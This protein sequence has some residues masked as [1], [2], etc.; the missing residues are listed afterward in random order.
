[1]RLISVNCEIVM[2]VKM[3]FIIFIDFFCWM[4][5]IIIGVLFLIG[6]LFDLKKFV[7]VWIVVFVLFVNFFINFF[8]YIFFIMIIR[9]KLKF[10]RGILRKF[11]INNLFCFV[12]K[13][14]LYIRLFVICFFL[15]MI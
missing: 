4:L 5:V 12:G 3:M 14:K 11:I 15:E 2:V 7:Y 9:K 6:N 10:L 13:L 1:M 8:F